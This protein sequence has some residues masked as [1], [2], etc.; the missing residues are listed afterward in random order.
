MTNT[1]RLIKNLEA[2]V[3]AG[4]P[5]RFY[6]GKYTGNGPAVIGALRRR[7]YCVTKLAEAYY[8]VSHTSPVEVSN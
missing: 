6:V 1:E 5:C 8:E 4:V 7:G 3:S 2:C